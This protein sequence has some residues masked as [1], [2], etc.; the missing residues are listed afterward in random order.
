M[1]FNWMHHTAHS[2]MTWL[3]RV[4]EPRPDVPAD[5]RLTARLHTT[6]VLADI[7]VLLAIAPFWLDISLNKSLVAG[8]IGQVLLVGIIGFF[9]G[10]TRHYRYAMR[11]IILGVSVAI[12]G[13]VADNVIGQR[14]PVIDPLPGFVICMVMAAFVLRGREIMIYGVGFVLILGTGYALIGEPI[15]G[16][17]ILILYYLMIVLVLS[18]GTAVR[19]RATR[20]H[21]ASEARYRSLFAQNV[22]AVILMQAN[23][24]IMEANDSA[25]A[26]LG[27]SLAMLRQTVYITLVPEREHADV[28]AKRARLLSGETIR[29]PYERTLIRADG[30]EVLVEMNAAYI[31]TADGNPPVLQL[32]LRDMADRKR[33]EQAAIET[34]IE[35]QRGKILATFIQGASHE[36]RTPLSIIGTNVHLLR[37]VTTEPAP[38][39]R[40]DT[41]QEQANR[42][43]RL[44]NM[45]MLMVKLDSDDPLTLG[46][47]DTD[48][49]LRDLTPY[50]RT[51]TEGSHTL[52][53]NIQAGLPAVIGD[54]H[55]L[56]EAVR[57]VF[58]NAVQYTPAGG[59]VTVRATAE[60]NR[61][62]LCITD[63]G[64]GMN[65]DEQARIF[66]RFY[67][68]DAAYSSEGF[69]LG[70][71][72]AR[73][74]IERHNGQIT[75]SSAPSMGTA[76]RITLATAVA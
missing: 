3:M 43:N 64:I 34:A 53:L 52:V 54:A 76:V 45:M 44:L 62:R 42:M 47:I 56:S 6:V 59:V 18:L 5:D 19:E 2:V 31:S 50:F 75:L 57:Q 71:A 69:G 46:A 25:A 10:R 37:R 66:E 68:A 13:T 7:V 21:R 60:D 39:G 49:L 67:R 8:L 58:N 32:V 24:E 73:S 12:L 30:T 29:K 70:L 20:Q 35:R 23:G 4:V 16:V 40:L 48:G 14:N 63:N 51:R 22:D 41:I 72:I 15:S 1:M 28:S 61:V 27:R 65:E 36:F 38:V 55:Y 11:I 26:L 74:V 33:A 17:V 9:L